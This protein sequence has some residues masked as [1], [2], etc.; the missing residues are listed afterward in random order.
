VAVSVERPESKARGELPADLLFDRVTELEGA[1]RGEQ[2]LALFVVRTFDVRPAAYFF[3]PA[4]F[5]SI[6]V[7]F[8]FC[9]FS[10]SERR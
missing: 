6:R 7:A 8:R 10:S 3:S 4:S 9:G 5:I 2:F 1:A